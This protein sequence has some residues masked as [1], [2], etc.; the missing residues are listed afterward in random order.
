MP[1]PVYLIANPAAPGDLP[2]G[3]E[4]DVRHTQS[5]LGPISLHISSPHLTVASLIFLSVC[6]EQPPEGMK[7]MSVQAFVRQEFEVHC[8]SASFLSL[9]SLLGGCADASGTCSQ[10]RT[11]RCPSAS[12][13][14]SASSSS[15]ST[16]AS[17]AVL[18]TP[19]VR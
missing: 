13:R 2:S 5:E 17:L 8:A 15:T 12:R 19:P 7:I 14:L 4:I 3:L 9:R 6:F 18:S 1:R 10:T 11:S 16:R